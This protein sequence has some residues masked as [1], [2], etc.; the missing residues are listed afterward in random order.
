MGLVET[1]PCPKPSTRPRRLRAEHA[2]TVY[3]VTDG[4][5]HVIQVPSIHNGPSQVGSV[6]TGRNQDHPDGVPSGR[7]VL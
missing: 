4:W 5:S 3:A 2:E 1:R 7:C 6:V